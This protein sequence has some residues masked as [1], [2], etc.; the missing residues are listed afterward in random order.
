MPLLPRWK[1]M[2]DESKS[3]VKKVGFFAFVSNIQEGNSL[4]PSK[5]SV[6]IH[7][8]INKNNQYSFLSEYFLND[9]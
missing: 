5:S 8:K 2:T 1:Y 4:Y 9:K 3:I 7:E 6:H